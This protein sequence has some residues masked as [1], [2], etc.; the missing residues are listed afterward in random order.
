MNANHHLPNS[1]PMLLK[2]CRNF[3]FNLLSVRLINIYQECSPK[4]N[5]FFSTNCKYNSK[6]MIIQDDK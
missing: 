2:R 5:A 3:Q 6:F 4:K 1:S